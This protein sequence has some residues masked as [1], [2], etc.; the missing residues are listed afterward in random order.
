MRILKLQRGL[1]SG[2][3]RALM[4]AWKAKSPD[5]VIESCDLDDGYF[6]NTSDKLKALPELVKASMSMGFKEARRSYRQI[7]LRSRTNLT[8]LEQV[9]GEAV[10]GRSFDCTLTLQTLM[11][12]PPTDRPNFIYTDHAILTNN[13]YPDGQAA[14]DRWRDWLP[15]ER[16]LIEKAALVFT[17]STHVGDSLVEFYHIPKERVR[18]VGAGFNARRADVNFDSVEHSKKIL[19]VGLDWERKG[20]PQLVEAFA[21]VREKHPDANL[22]VVGCEPEVKVPGVQV[23]GVV[24]IERVGELMSDACCFCMPSLREP[25][26]LVYLEAMNAG[27]PVVALNLGAPRDFVVNGETGFLV[28]PHDIP[29]LADALEN[30][31]ANSKLCAMMG[32]RARDRVSAEYT[33]EVTQAR[34]AKAMREVMGS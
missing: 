6:D 3:S 29:G 15:M 7:A 14:I 30:L 34:M 9:V 11:P 21:R 10:R 25:F 2:V 22:I 4:E 19:F 24:P 1:F 27:L 23:L 8:R 20:G 16:A 5:D 12:A 28:E 26:G 17:M 32:K 31:V 18:L 33:W 13:Y